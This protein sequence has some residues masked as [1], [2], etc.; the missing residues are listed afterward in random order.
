MELALI[1][2]LLLGPLFWLSLDLIF[3]SY[4]FSIKHFIFPISL[5]TIL[6]ASNASTQLLYTVYHQLIESPFQLVHWNRIQ[7]YLFMSISIVLLFLSFLLGRLL[8]V[9]WK[10]RRLKDREDIVEVALIDRIM[11]KSNI[12]NNELANSHVLQASVFNE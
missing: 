5:V 6:F 3:N 12:N 11:G 10:Q 2:N 4:P 1:Y 8:F 9:R 7:D